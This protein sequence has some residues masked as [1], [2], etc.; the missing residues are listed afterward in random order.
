M[1]TFPF[2][3]LFF[4]LNFDFVLGFYRSFSSPEQIVRE[5]TFLI[6]DLDSKGG[7]LGGQDGGRSQD[8]RQVDEDGGG[9]ENEGRI[10]ETD[11]SPRY[12]QVKQENN[13]R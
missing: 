8:C 12:G 13:K 11:I 6:E 9:R 1:S 7:L 3:F 10:K 5:R 2:L 4:Y